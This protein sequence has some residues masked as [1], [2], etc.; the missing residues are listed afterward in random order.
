M[1][2][3]QQEAYICAV[4][5]NLLNDIVCPYEQSERETWSIQLAEAEAY[6]ADPN[7]DAPMLTAMA[8]TRGITVSELAAKVMENNNLFRS[9]AGEILGEQQ[10]LLDELYAL[11]E[12]CTLED[13]EAIQWN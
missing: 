13:I 3:V 9:A 1:V 2:D 8:S 11:P 12:D 6:A 4:C 5:S 10:K 7:V